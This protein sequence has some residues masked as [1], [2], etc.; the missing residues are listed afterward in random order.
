[1]AATKKRAD[2]K[3]RSQDKVEQTEM[4]VGFRS[5]ALERRITRR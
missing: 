2:T 3:K 1:M 5:R 4:D